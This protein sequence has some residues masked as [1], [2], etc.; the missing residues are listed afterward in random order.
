MT[1]RFGNILLITAV[2]GL[3]V[4]GAAAEQTTFKTPGAAAQALVTAAQKGA[5]EQVIAILGE[6]VRDALSTGSPGQDQVEKAVLLK[7]AEESTIAR[8]DVQNPNR[9]IV[10][11]GRDAWPFPVPAGENRHAMAV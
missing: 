4:T 7:L 11:L 6:E 8:P 5:R 2:A 1:F 3:C 9:A 10:Y